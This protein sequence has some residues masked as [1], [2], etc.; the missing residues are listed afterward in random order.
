MQYSVAAAG[1]AAIAGRVS[2]TFGLQGPAFTVNTLCSAS[3]VA[4]DLGYHELERKRCSRVM[5]AGVNLLMHPNIFQ[6]MCCLHAASPDSKCKTFDR[7][8]DGT[9]RG[10]AIGAMQL[11]FV[12][13]STSDQ[14][15]LGGTAINNDG[16]SS[17]MI[18]PNG[19]AQES[20]ISNLMLQVNVVPQH[21]ETH[22]TGTKL[23][24]PIEFEAISKA[25]SSRHYNSALE[26]GA[27]KTR[28][29]HTEGS[30][31]IMGVFT[32]VFCMLQHAGT[33]NL[34]FCVI[35]ELL[36]VDDLAVVLPSS[37]TVT[38]AQ[39]NTS[40]R[41]AGVSAFGMSGTNAHTSLSVMNE[42]TNKLNQV[43]VTKYKYM[44]F[45]WGRFNIADPAPHLNGG[46]VGLW[47]ARPTALNCAH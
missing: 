43:Q 16:A 41:G 3:L 6:V 23:G 46:I 30:A 10:E 37:V 29:G 42:A 45:G 2:Y 33:P 22:G 38:A 14:I 11:S 28:L 17:S 4:I 25:F 7:S 13:G 35:N 8:A 12:H 44:K 36:N 9:A 27:L 39:P 21:L 18:A 24:D 32:A 5:V 1:Q 19:L 31:G 20:L 26:L 40:Q 34:Q 47:E 15:T